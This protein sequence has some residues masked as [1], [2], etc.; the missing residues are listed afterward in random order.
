MSYQIIRTCT[1]LH[2]SEV[3]HVIA[4]YI[5]KG[6]NIETMMSLRGEKHDISLHILHQAGRRTLTATNGHA[7]R[8]V[9]P[10]V[11]CATSLSIFQFWSPFCAW[12]LVLFLEPISRECIT[13]YADFVSQNA[14]FMYHAQ[15]KSYE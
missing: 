10:F 11:F 1:H 2:L 4:E 7:K 5:A 3:K 9:L 6:H 13:K 8:Y 15:N 14:T 12:C